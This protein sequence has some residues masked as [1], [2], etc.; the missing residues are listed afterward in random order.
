MTSLFVVIFKIDVTTR[1]GRFPFQN[2]DVYVT[3]F[4]NILNIR[5]LE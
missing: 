4:A 3:S 5:T 1:N 2:Q